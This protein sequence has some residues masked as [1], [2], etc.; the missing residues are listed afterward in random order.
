MAGGSECQLASPG[1]RGWGDPSVLREEPTVPFTLK[2]I[3]ADSTVS[4]GYFL[5]GFQKTH[6]A[7]EMKSKWDLGDNELSC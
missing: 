7:S 1:G 3:P 4:S 2:P 6:F 5:E